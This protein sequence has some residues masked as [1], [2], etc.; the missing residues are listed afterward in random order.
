MALII[1]NSEYESFLYQ[2]CKRCS[3]YYFLNINLTPKLALLKYELEKNGFLVMA[4]I[5]LKAEDFMRV[6]RIFKDKCERGKN[7]LAFIYVGGHGFCHDYVV[8]DCFVPIDFQKNFHNNNHK[9][10]INSKNHISLVSLLENFIS[11]EKEKNETNFSVICF[12]DM[13]RKD[14]DLSTNHKDFDLKDSN[15]NDLKYIII[16]CWYDM[17][18]V[19]YFNI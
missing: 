17:L 11:S 4:Y 18:T 7:V 6:V 9:K 5:D 1:G 15:L 13:C 12:W 14:S 10:L 16:Y 3:K 2:N 8:G 19:S